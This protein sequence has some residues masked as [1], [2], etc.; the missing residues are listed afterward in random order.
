[1]HLNIFSCLNAKGLQ[2][3]GRSEGLSF[4]KLFFGEMLANAQVALSI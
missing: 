2:K 3:H 4:S 1:M